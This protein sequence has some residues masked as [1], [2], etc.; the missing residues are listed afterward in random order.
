VTKPGPFWVYV[1]MSKT[2]GD[3]YIGQTNDL[4]ARLQEHNDPDFRG[5]RVLTGEPS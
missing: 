2:T 3:I 1:L 5:V 4:E